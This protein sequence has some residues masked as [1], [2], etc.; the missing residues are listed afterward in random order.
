MHGSHASHDGRSYWPLLTV[1]TDGKL[2]Q[3]IEDVDD[4]FDTKKKDV[5][6]RDTNTVDPRRVVRPTRLPPHPALPTAPTTPVG[7]AHGSIRRDA[8]IP[9]VSAAVCPQPRCPVLR[10][11]AP[12]AL[13]SRVGPRLGGLG[14][15]GV[16]HRA[17]LLITRVT[18]TFP[19][20][21]SLATRSLS[22]R[23]WGHRHTLPAAPSLP[24]RCNPG[25]P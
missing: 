8:C 6:L 7:I 11:P 21:A 14:P 9:S 20:G 5:Y 17:A 22:R 12:A 19:H 4:L 24:C 13:H 16:L 25:K 15:D 10:S 3:A 23:G 1:H 18:A 2:L